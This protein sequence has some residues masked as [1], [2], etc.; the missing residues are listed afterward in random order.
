MRGGGST[1]FLVPDGGA[2]ANSARPFRQAV[3]PTLAEEEQQMLI[4]LRG[5]FGAGKST[6]V[7]AILDAGDARPIY[8]ALAQRPEAYELSLAGEPTYVLGPYLTACGGLDA[9]QPY[10]L[11][12]PLIERYAQAGNVVFEGALVSGCWGAVGRLLERYGR[13]AIVAFLDTPVDECIRR[14]QARRALR[15]DDRPF[16]PTNLI[17]KHKTIARLKQ[18]LDAAGI[19]RTMVSSSENAAADV[20]SFLTQMSDDRLRAEKAASGLVCSCMEGVLP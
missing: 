5:T 18:K 12:C 3:S 9:V 15:G 1:V 19:V 10:E 11:I 13:E 7:R 2:Q 6:A 14:V 17:S 20:V 4:N 8:G 16:D